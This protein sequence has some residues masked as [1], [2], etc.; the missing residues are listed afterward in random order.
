MKKDFFKEF[1]K[2]E[3]KLREVSGVTSDTE[4]FREI[5]KKAK[6]NNPIIEY[7]EEIIWDLYALR[8]VFAHKDRSK[9]IA[10]VNK[11]AFDRLDETIELLK[12]PPKVGQSFKKDVYSATTE[13]IMET[14]MC[15]MREN[16]FTHVPVYENKKFVGVFSETTVFDW[17]ADCSENR[18]S[19]FYLKPLSHINKKYFNSRNNLHKFIPRDLDIF[20]AYKVFEDNILNG[21]RMGAIFITKNGREDDELI[22]IITAW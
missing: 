1:K 2:L 18:N 22:G 14:V 6:K 20:S 15:K 19:D 10:D 13:D 5:I 21:K 17:F 11:L 3:K 9:Y 8:N 16:L 4:N 7:K 12:N